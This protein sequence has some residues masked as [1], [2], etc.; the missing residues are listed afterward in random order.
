MDCITCQ[1]VL[2]KNLGTFDQWLGRLQVAKET[3]YNMLHFSPIQ[4]L[5]LSNSAYC[6]K[7]QLQLNPVF[8]PK[9]SVK[10]YTF[11]DVKKLVDLMHKDWEMLSITDLV[12]NHT[13]NESPW[14]LEHPECSYNLMRAVYQVVRALWI[15][16]HP[17]CS[18]NLINSPHLKPAYVLDRI[19][20][21][22]SMEIAEGR[23]RSKGVPPEIRTQDHLV[24]SAICHACP[25]F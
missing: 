8:T 25:S 15:L 12:L 10:Q 11:T 3:G 14:I 19:I 18:Y 16:E 22:Y 5:G 21:H 4:E 9:G 24:V 23:W 6:L 13:A 1:T 2:A 17:E 20:W 7:D